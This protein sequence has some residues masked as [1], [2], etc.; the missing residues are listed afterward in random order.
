MLKTTEYDTF[1]ILDYSSTLA[2]GSTLHG[3]HSMVLNPSNVINPLPT[4][5][6]RFVTQLTIQSFTKSNQQ[7]LL[8]T[9]DV[10]AAATRATPACCGS[11]RT[12]WPHDSVMYQTHGQSSYDSFKT[13][14]R[15][16]FKTTKVTSTYSAFID[17][18]HGQRIHVLSQTPQKDSL[19][20]SEGT[21]STYIDQT[22]Q[23]STHVLSQTLQTDSLTSEGKD[24]GSTD[25][26]HGKSTP[27][28]STTPRTDSFSTIKGTYSAFTDHTHEENSRDSPKALQTDSLGAAKYTTVYS[29]FM[30]HGSLVVIDKSEM[31]SSF[32]KQAGLSTSQVRLSLSS[33]SPSLSPSSSG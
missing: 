33:L 10:Q 18:T 31:A 22:R 5:Y 17:Q 24:D 32:Q 23:K 4:S 14:Q 7:Q 28:S 25:Q 27:N 15:D 2:A 8:S 16:S 29:V 11:S 20:A 3:K 13:L 9:H 26:T 6:M 12:F 19:R 30:D 1:F 21:Y